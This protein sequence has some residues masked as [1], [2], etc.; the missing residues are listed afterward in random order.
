MA[1]G[2]I[3]TWI[4]YYDRSYEQAKQAILTR[5]GITTPEMSD[6]TE[7]NPYIW[8]LDVFLGIAELLHYYI[9]NAAREVFLHSARQYKSAQKIAKLFTYRLK[10]FTAASV[11]VKFYLAEESTVLVTIPAGTL[12]KAGDVE[13]RTASG[14]TIPI[15]DLFTEVIAIQRTPVVLN[16]VSTGNPAQKVLLEDNTVDKSMTVAVDSV[17]YSFVE[18]FLLSKAVDK[19]FTTEIGTDQ[20]PY[21]IFGDGIDA[22]IPPLNSNIVINYFTSLG[23]EGNVAIGEIDTIDSGASFSAEVFVTNDMYATGGSGIETLKSLKRTI[24]AS[25]RTLNR[26]VTPKDFR[27]IAESHNGVQKAFEDYRCGAAVDIFIVPT[28]TGGAT[29]ILLEE[30]RELFYDETKLI[31][32]E[33][34]IKPAGRIMATV[35]ANVRVSDVYNRTIVTAAVKENL[36]LFLSAE[37]QEISGAVRIGDIYQTIETTEGVDYC[38]VLLLSTVPEATNVNGLS[39]LN[40]TRSLLPV[41]SSN[42][43]WHIKYVGGTSYELRKGSTF[44]DTFEFGQTI[45]FEE[46]VFTIN[47]GDYTLGDVWE[48][49]TYRYNG[50][51]ELA[52]PSILTIDD[53]HI[54]LTVTGGV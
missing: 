20:K 21:I 54:N 38:E 32:M 2:L 4:G 9:D 43:V 36:K 24:P 41:S 31:M 28:G 30:V 26:A 29:P 12:I 51:I 8:I 42:Q 23:T 34:I 6:H 1:I 16:Y 14:T 53:A 37:N 40:W 39:T 47:S 11:S 15:G 46:V 50:T 18:N 13:Y 25:L 10:G 33:V 49:T 52:E 27:D 17:Q 3:N 44:V 22:I 7:S 19:V 35:S 48:F 45:N 5:L